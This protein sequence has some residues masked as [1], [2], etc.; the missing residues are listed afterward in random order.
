MSS[1]SPAVPFSPPSAL[2]PA[3]TAVWQAA[4]LAGVL[5]WAYLPMLR[6]FADKWL[7]DPQYSHGLLVPFFSAY[8]IWR[9]GQGG[10]VALR[11]AP[12]VGCGLLVAILGLRARPA[13][14]CSTN[15][16]RRRCCWR[17]P[18]S[19]SRSAGCRSSSGPGRRS[20]S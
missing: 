16:T 4:A 18:R 12:V 11:P 3:R 13:R 1:I 8:L 6:V 15:W 17:S 14:C 7:N 19:P 5:G 9:A 10:A 2:A 20:P